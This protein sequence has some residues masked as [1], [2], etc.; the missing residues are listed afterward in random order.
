MDHGHRS[1]TAEVAASERAVVVDAHLNEPVWGAATDR[2]QRRRSSVRWRGR[3]ALTL[4]ILGGVTAS[5]AADALAAL[6]IRPPRIRVAPPVK[7]HLPPVSERELV[8]VAESAARYGDETGRVGTQLDTRLSDAADQVDSDVAK[9]GRT[10]QARAALRECVSEG[11]QSTAEDYGQA[12]ADYAATGRH[13]FP[14]VYASVGAAMYGCIE[15]QTGAP[16]NVVKPAAEYFAGHLHEQFA[17]VARTSSSGAAQQRWLEFLAEDVVASPSQPLPAST[18]SDDP[19][20]VLIASVAGVLAL[21]ALVGTCVL[22]A[23]R[24]P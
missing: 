7:L 18:S 9:I 21:L 11:V 23:R 17:G 13:A 22:R 1:A 4:V 3:A 12:L 15:S 16:S 19:P 24:R 5:T 8:V 10:A 20:W 6:P 2:T 14:G